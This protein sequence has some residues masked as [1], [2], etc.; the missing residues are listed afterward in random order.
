[1]QTAQFSGT[2]HADNSILKTQHADSFI[3]MHLDLV[4]SQNTQLFE[5]FK[6]NICV[7]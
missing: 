1:M 2:N 4:I 6:Q 3:L 5:D 7:N